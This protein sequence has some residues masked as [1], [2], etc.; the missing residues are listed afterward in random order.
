MKAYLVSRQTI[1]PR[2]HDLKA[3]LNL[4]K[5]VNSSFEDIN[6]PCIN[7]SDFAVAPRYPDDFDDL[8]I[9]DAKNAQRDAFIIK[10]FV[11]QNFFK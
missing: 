5:E 6:K 1:F 9:D 7:L 8:T 11:L 2:T 10:D 3:L 4:C